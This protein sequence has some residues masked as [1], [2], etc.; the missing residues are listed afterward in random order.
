MRGLQPAQRQ[1]AILIDA[2]RIQTGLIITIFILASL[3][4]Q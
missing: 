1:T 3:G 4:R 2:K